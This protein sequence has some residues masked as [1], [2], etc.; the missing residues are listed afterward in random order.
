[1]LFHKVI[2]TSFKGYNKFGGRPQNPKSL[3]F[4]NYSSQLKFPRHS[5]KFGPTFE[6]ILNIEFK[7][8]RLQVNYA[9][10]STKNWKLVVV[11]IL[12]MVF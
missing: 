5:I 10:S 12:C 4:G 3:S 6:Q 8:K 2:L 7:K 9:F 11:Q 1:M